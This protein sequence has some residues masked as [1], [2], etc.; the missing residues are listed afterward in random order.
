MQHTI[1]N[2]RSEVS[3]AAHYLQFCLRSAPNLTYTALRHAPHSQLAVDPF[4][5]LYCILC[6]EL[7]LQDLNC[8]F[9]VLTTSVTWLSTLYNA[10]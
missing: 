5:Y 10:N 9:T 8:M 3:C 1:C 7:A 4:I 2:Y 6:Q